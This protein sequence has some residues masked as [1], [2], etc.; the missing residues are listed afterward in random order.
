M[1]RLPIGQLLLNH[2]RLFR[3]ALLAGLVERGF[4]DIR[5]AHLHVF[6]SIKAVGTRPSDL[7]D[8][9]N[10]GRSSMAELIDDLE[11][12][13]YVERRADPTDGRAKL[14][15][16]TDRGWQA[17]RAARAVIGEVEA[18]YA[19][20]LGRE[21]LETTLAALEELLADLDPAVLTGYRTPPS[22]E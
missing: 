1:R 7:A 18:E 2:L 20:R 17:M 15:C 5:P 14:V 11:A 13:G 4:A 21:R 8:W 12:K 3:E 16:L 9:T 19:A 10:M 6:G 22:A